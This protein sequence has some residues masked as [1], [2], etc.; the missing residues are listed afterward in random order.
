EEDTEG[1][2]VYHGWGRINARITLQALALDFPP[3]LA[4]P[5]AQSV[6]EGDTL[7]LTLTASDSNFT[8][9]ALSIVTAPANVSLSD[10]GDGSAD[11]EFT[12]LSGQVGSHTVTVAA[13]D[14]TFADTV[15]F[16]VDVLPSC[17]CNCFGD[18]QCDAVTNVLDV[19]HAV[20]V[21]F[22]GGADIPD[23]NPSCPNT[24]TDVD[25][26]GFTN[27]IDVVKFVNVAFKGQTAAA[28]FCDPC[29]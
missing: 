26:S 19:V 10:N 2:D 18:P 25:C 14:G 3:I 15:S 12:P 16:S 5:G 4:D 17:G 7:K 29:L 22:K 11:F 23:S 1:F 27:V 24:T 13:S 9:P 8:P 6:A 21:A 20:N 28:Q